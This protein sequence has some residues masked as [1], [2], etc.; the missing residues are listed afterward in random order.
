VEQWGVC[1]VT[2]RGGVRHYVDIKFLQWLLPSLVISSKLR[3]T[4][5]QTRN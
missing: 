3:A 1:A 5:F 4:G 2:S